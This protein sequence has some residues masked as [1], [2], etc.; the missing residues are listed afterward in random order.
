MDERQMR[1]I[2]VSVLLAP[3]L[4]MIFALIAYAQRGYFAFGGE[5]IALLLPLCAYIYLGIR[6]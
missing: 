4:Y 1:I 5:C 6:G 3:V 2:G